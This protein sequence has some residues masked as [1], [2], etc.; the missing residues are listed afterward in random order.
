MNANPKEEITVCPKCKGLKHLLV[1][2]ADLFGDP[3]EFYEPCT[4]LINEKYTQKL[5][6]KIYN[7][8]N[9]KN[10]KLLDKLQ[11][12][13]FVHGPEE[14]FLPHLKYVLLRQSLEFSFSVM[15]DSR[16]LRI[17][18]GDDPELKDISSWQKSFLVLF[19]GHVGYKNKALPGMICELLNVRLLSAKTTWIHY[20][21]RFWGK[22]CIEF[23]DELQ[24]I[25][26]NHFITIDMCSASKKST[27]QEQLERT[28]CNDQLLSSF[29]KPN[30]KNP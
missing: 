7:Q 3:T 18:L 12:N 9:L 27:S 13:I 17:Y 6:L 4:C 24:E 14:K 25:L 5:G 8:K 22:G 19:L 16:Y 10:S 26:T 29:N 21:E 28:D 2:K 23:S 1:V 20:P 15:D 30:G 11:A